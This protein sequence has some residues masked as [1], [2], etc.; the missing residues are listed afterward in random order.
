MKYGILTLERGKVLRSEGIEL[1][2]G[3]VMKDIEG[4][5]YKYLGILEIDR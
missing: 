1:L 3:S 5:G 2:N 4:S